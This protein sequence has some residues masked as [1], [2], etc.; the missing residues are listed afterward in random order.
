MVRQAPDGILLFAQK[1]SPARSAAAALEAGLLL[2][3]ALGR[4]D[5][6]EAR[7]GDR[8]AALDRKSTRLN[9]SHVEIS[10]AVFCLKKK[11]HPDAQR[12]DIFPSEL[13]DHDRPGHRVHEPDSPFRPGGAC[14]LL[15]VQLE[16]REDTAAPLVR[17]RHS[18][19]RKRRQAV[20]D[21]NERCRERAGSRVVREARGVKYQRSCRSAIET[22]VELGHRHRRAL[23]F[24]FF[25]DAATTEIYT[26]SLHDA[27]PIFTAINR[28]C[29]DHLVHCQCAYELFEL[30]DR[31]E[32]VDPARS[33]HFATV[34]HVANDVA[35]GGEL[36]GNLD[37]KSTRLNSS[38]VEI[39]YA[40]FCLK[41]KK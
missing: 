1:A 39:S 20:I 18:V 14:L 16:R 23:R 27:L 17:G 24:F 15:V 8:L 11:K 34:V 4:G 35:S 10:Y 37:R 26:L 32:Q 30:R 41:K 21:A 19:Q 9:S 12:H 2:H 33:L 29:D 22:A 31:T 28:Q 5:G 38:H 25:N 36:V 7:V 6:L 13:P 3:R 40:V